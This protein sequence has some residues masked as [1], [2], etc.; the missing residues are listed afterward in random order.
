MPDP[1]SPFDPAERL[2]R[3]EEKH[4]NLYSLTEKIADNADTTAKALQ[5]LVVIH[6]ETQVRADSDR[7]TIATLENWITRIENKHDQLYKVV[8]R[9]I[10]IGTGVFGVL[11]A[12][13]YA[14][15]LPLILDGGVG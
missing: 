3:L 9:Y 11:A 15:I 7:E 4:D 13:W 6:K 5:E 14:G 12:L 8:W 10:Y 2:V 1:M